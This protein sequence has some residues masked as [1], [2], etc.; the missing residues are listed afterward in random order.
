MRS[1]VTAFILLV[2]PLAA[3]AAEPGF[4][5]TSVSPRVLHGRDDLP[6]GVFAASPG[7]WRVTPPPRVPA[8]RDTLRLVLPVG[9]PLPAGQALLFECE[10]RAAPD[11]QAS[12]QGGLVLDLSPL[13]LNEGHKPA[14]RFRQI[15]LAGT[16]WERFRLTL[17]AQPDPLPEWGIVLSPSHFEQPV[18]LRGVR[19]RYLAPGDEL[20]P[21]LAYSGQAPDAPWRA[22]AAARIERHRKSD[23]RL[24]VVDP[25]GHPVAGATGRVEQRRHA[26]P[27]GTAAVA[28]RLVDADV[29]F[30]DPTMT[31][32]RFVADNAR[33]R[34][35]L[36]RL[37]N[38]VVLENDLKWP[39]WTGADPNFVPE[40]TLQALVWLRDHR[41]PV[42]GHTLIWASWRMTPPWLR[43]LEDDPAKLQAA[44]LR[45]IRDAAAA[46]RDYTHAWDVLNEP[47]SHREIIERLGPDAVAEWFHTARATLPGHLLLLNDY[48][49]VG[50]GGNPA[51]RRALYGLLDNLRAA[52]ASPDAL[53]LQSHFLSDRLTPPVGIWEILDE[54][55]AETG[56]PLAATEFDINF[57]NDQV[58]AD[59]TRDFLTAW[60][61]HPATRSFTMWGFFGRSHWF[62]ERGAMFRDDWS[63]KPNLAA[64]ER[65]VLHEWWTRVTFATNS[66]GHASIRAF[67]GEHEV[68]VTAPGRFPVVRHVA[69]PPG[70]L[71]FEIVLHPVGAA[72]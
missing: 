15:L 70:G 61:A 10:L 60:F 68:R 72:P 38:H 63:P 67:H 32:A 1:L 43:D 64:Y 59:Y 24:R 71:D 18:E 69:L 53:G 6:D 36:L 41:L 48:D 56:L 4:D 13:P 50:N 16:D 62:G 17:P 5:Q 23:L 58:Q 40:V 22:E 47:L 9:A 20:A 3:P 35:E 65:L 46:T 57:P 49:L 8:G 66:D 30:R 25:L 28:S 39:Q 44:I 27:F 29:S 7:L 54:I 19:L 51:R 33:Y 52:G 21:T 14:S 11:G 26:Y 42:K 12:G 37:F 2:K 45:H 34:A 31:R 55:H